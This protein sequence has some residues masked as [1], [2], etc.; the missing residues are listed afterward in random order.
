MAKF[1][2]DV[3][4]FTVEVDEVLLVDIEDEGEVGLG[5]G[6]EIRFL[7]FRLELRRRNEAVSDADDADEDVSTEGHCRSPSSSP[8]LASLSE[9]I[10]PVDVFF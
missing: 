7:A 3:P 9:S 10:S 2:V 1:V 6:E 4:F 8:S 5:L